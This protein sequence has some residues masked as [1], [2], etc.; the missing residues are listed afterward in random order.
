VG[1]TQIKLND[2]VITFPIFYP[3]ISSV[4]TNYPPCDYID[5]LEFFGY[6]N[7]LVSAFDIWNTNHR[8]ALS[9]ETRI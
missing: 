4:K 7:Y 3:S 1:R 6:P 5:F 2:K 8:N 9:E